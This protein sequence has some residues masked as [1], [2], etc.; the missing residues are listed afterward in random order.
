MGATVVDAKGSIR[1]ADETLLTG[2]RG[3]RGALGV[4]VEI[5]IKVYTLDKVCW[6]STLREIELTC[7]K[8]LAGAIIYQ[9]NDLAATIRQYNQSYKQQKA[10]GIPSALNLYQSATNGPEGKALAA[11][12]VWASEDL[13]EGQGWL[14]KVSSWAP[15]AINTVPTTTMAGFN[16][17]SASLIPKCTHGTIF[18]VNVHELTP[19]ILDVISIHTALQPNQPPTLFGI[20]E[21]RAEAP[22]S[23]AGSVFA[24]RSPHFLIEI[25][26]MTE[27]AEALDDVQAWGRNFYNALM[28]TNPGNINRAAYLP[29]TRSKDIDLKLTYGSRHETLQ[30]IKQ[31]YDPLNVFKHSLVKF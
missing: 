3:G 13:E 28:K 10:E 17:I 16:E 18:A 15:V 11:F 30:K 1:E 12:F 21:L 27:E 29:L 20:H 4:I 22:W 25:I 23:P 8:I 7:T 9:P 14:S 6:T 26:P 31:E 19:G 5:K 24:T 2:L